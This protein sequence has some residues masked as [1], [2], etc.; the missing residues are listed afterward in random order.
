M[1]KAAILTR[2]DTINFGTILQNYALQKA[3]K[4]LGYSVS[5][6]DDRQPRRLYSG[7]TEK[8]AAQYSLKER[9]YHWYDQTKEKRA[10]KRNMAIRRKCESFKKRFIEYDLIE[11]IDEINESYDIV[12]SGSDQIW[13]QAA[14]PRMYPFFMQD[15]VSDKIIKASYAVSVGSDYSS[16]KA[17]DVSSYLNDF[18]LI[19]VRESSSA[20]I[21]SRYTDKKAEIVCDPV[22]LLPSSQWDALA[23]QRRRKGRYVFCYFLSNN[24]WYSRKIEELRQRYPNSQV[25]VFEKKPVPRPGCIAIDTCSPQDFLN[26]I[27]Y[28]DCVLTDSYHV[29]LFSLIFH[30]KINVLERF[31]N[32]DNNYQNERILYLM[33]RLGIKNHFLKENDDL[34]DGDI[35]YDDVDRQLGTFTNDSRAYLMEILNYR[36]D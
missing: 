28:A 17:A 5:T 10:D 18:D 24:P 27:K 32:I 34:N 15:F 11:S 36:K 29:F 13:A 33:D 21:L 9:I 35:D 4:A 23:G 8:K 30:R 1:K 3:I 20:K 25:F 12:I 14:E 2:T 22:L 16:E 7:K 6:I 19:S 31:G 26:N